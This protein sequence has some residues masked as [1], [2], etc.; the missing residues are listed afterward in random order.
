MID[1]ALLELEG[2]VF[3]TRDLRRLSLRDAL[4]EH[5]LAPSIDHEAIDGW[6]PRVVVERSLT[7]QGVKFDEVLV[8]ILTS[9]AERAFSTRLAT[10][11][12][13]FCEN[14]R[15]FIEHAAGVARLAIVTSARRGDV[16]TM[17]RLASLSD[18]FNVI[19]SA[20]DVLD[21][22]PSGEGHRIA[23]GRLGKRRPVILKRTVALEHGLPGMRAARDAGL[24]CVAV[25]PLGAHLAMEADV[26]VPTLAGLTIR[27][28]DHFVQTGEEQVQ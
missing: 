2:V 3:D 1:A 9:R 20:E 13:A 6:P 21:A 28:L 15:P 16:D 25:G 24:T 5:G 22:K 19:V 14:A 26:Y 18:C 4:L 11:G 8:D 10:S 23:L 17:L 7:L 12:A 27:S